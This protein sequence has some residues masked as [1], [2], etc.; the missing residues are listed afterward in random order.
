MSRFGWKEEVSDQSPGKN[1]LLI[2]YLMRVNACVFFANI[3]TNV[4][5]FWQ[6]IR[7]LDFGASKMN[8]ALRINCEYSIYLFFDDDFL[9]VIRHYTPM[10]DAVSVHGG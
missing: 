5:G 4:Y 6:P 2:R 9:V 3:M 8:K 1:K 10:R 7:L